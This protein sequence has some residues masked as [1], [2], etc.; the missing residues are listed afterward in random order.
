MSQS[1]LWGH[2]RLRPLKCN[3]IMSPRRSLCHIW[4][5]SLWVM[6]KL[7]SWGRTDN[8]NTRCLWHV[9]MNVWECEEGG[10]C[11]MNTQ[12][13]KEKRFSCVNSLLC[14]Q[15]CLSGV[16]WNTS[17]AS[18]P[19]PT[20]NMHWE[21]DF[22]LT[23]NSDKRHHYICTTFTPERCS[24]PPPSPIKPNVK[25]QAQKNKNETLKRNSSTFRNQMLINEQTGG[26]KTVQQLL[27]K[28]KSSL[29]KINRPGCDWNV[30]QE[31]K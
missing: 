18:G 14:A 11:Q 20:P 31:R 22:S 21:G 30:Q 12:K 27:V 9:G 24:D 26:R 3:Q 1:V 23:L 19:F 29:T 2:N 25:F 6:L 8:W 17:W 28:K 5:N 15:N 7:C 10:G 16:Q 4:R 13:L